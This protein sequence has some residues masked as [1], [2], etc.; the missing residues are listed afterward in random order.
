MGGLGNDYN[1]ERLK[2]CLDRQKLLNYVHHDDVSPLSYIGPN[3]KMGKFCRVKPFSSIGPKGFSFAFHRDGTPEEMVHTGGVII[4]DYVEIG[5]LCTVAGG[6]IIDTV[7][8][9]HTKLDDHIHIAHNCIIGKN[10]I[11]AASASLGGGVVMQDNVWIGLNAT[12]NNKVHVGKWAVIGSGATVINDVPD[13]AV[14]AGCPAKV[15]RYRD[16]PPQA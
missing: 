4:G 5:A 1:P 12:I 2:W 9:D 16:V 13:Y 14:V 6:T 15:L 3:V 8:G 7:L 10:C 11:F